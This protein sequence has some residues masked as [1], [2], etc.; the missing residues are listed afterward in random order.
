M[1]HRSQGCSGCEFEFILNFIDA[2]LNGDG[3]SIGCF[4]FDADSKFVFTNDT[5]A[6]APK[7]GKIRNHFV[8]FELFLES[9]AGDPPA[10]ATDRLHFTSSNRTLEIPDTGP[11][12]RKEFLKTVSMIGTE[13]V[14]RITLEQSGGLSLADRLLVLFE[15]ILNH[16]AVTGGPLFA[17]QHC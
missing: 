12:P 9:F 11:D 13:P 14:V 1:N 15:K 7:T 3:D 2:I 8:K 16:Q 10:V 4:L 5:N 17:S 6:D